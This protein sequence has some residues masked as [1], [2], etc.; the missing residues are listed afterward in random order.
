MVLSCR[1]GLFGVKRY[2]RFKADPTEKLDPWM[3][4]QGHSRSFIGT[5]TYRSAT[6]DFYQRSIATMGLSCTVSETNGDFSRKSQFFPTP[7]ILHPAEGFP[8]ELGTGAQVRKIRMMGYRAEKEVWRYLQP[9][10]Y[11][12]RTWQTDG[13]TPGD[14]KDRAYA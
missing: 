5:D 8:L 2:E 4:F 6:C 14:S 12:A 9:S 1:I 7:C 13:Q 3:T 10:G 11:N